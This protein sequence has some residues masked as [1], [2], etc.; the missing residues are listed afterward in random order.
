MQS[1]EVIWA[2]VAQYSLE[3]SSVGSQEE[4]LSPE[5]LGLVNVGVGVDFVLAAGV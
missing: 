2:Q 3:G 4:E 1:E 5:A